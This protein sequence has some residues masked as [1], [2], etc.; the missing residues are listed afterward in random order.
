MSLLFSELNRSD[1]V[2]ENFTNEQSSNSNYTYSPT[3]S[4][5]SESPGRPSRRAML[6]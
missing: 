1:A 5:P 4:Y 2:C 6:R 3:H